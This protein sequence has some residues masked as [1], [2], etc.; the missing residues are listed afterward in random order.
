MPRA[1]IFGKK[2]HHHKDDGA[3]QDDIVELQKELSELREEFDD[4]QSRLQI[5]LTTSQSLEEQ[6]TIERESAKRLGEAL[7]ASEARCEQL[8]HE[9][10]AAEEIRKTAVSQLA[11]E[12]VTHAEKAKEAKAQL[13]LTEQSM[14][15]LRCEMES[16]QK[17]HPGLHEPAQA[18]MVAEASALHV[19]LQ[20]AQES[21]R[22]LVASEAQQAE[23]VKDLRSA[24]A[25][26]E[27]SLSRA[28]AEASSA[29][30]ERAELQVDLETH[31]A[32]AKALQ[33]SF[34]E[35]GMAAQ[36]DELQ[37]LRELDSEVK[38]RDRLLSELRAQL[39]RPRQLAPSMVSP[40]VLLNFDGRPQDKQDDALAQAKLRFEQNSQRSVALLAELN[41]AEETCAALRTEHETLRAAPPPRSVSNLPAP[42]DA[43]TEAEVA[44]LRL[45]IER[46][47]QHRSAQ[48]AKTEEL[49]AELLQ[50]KAG[51]AALVAEALAQQSLAS[52]SALQGAE[53]SKEELHNEIRAMRNQVYAERS[54]L[55]AAFR[56]ELA[57]EEAMC[58]RAQDELVSA[59][60]A[61]EANVAKGA[62]DD[63]DLQHRLQTELAEE[64]ERSARLAEH[65]W[66][67]E[68][69]RNR[70]L[71]EVAQAVEFEADLTTLAKQVGRAAKSIA[72]L[73]K[74][75]V[76]KAPDLRCAAQAASPLEVVA[77]SSLLM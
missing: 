5:A 28:R 58:K 16:L 64:V 60:L 36:L 30:A 12:A 54:D 11:S 29:I 69:G 73:T 55:Q 66:R 21:A 33:A 25:E 47:E 68:E 42:Q 24:L 18:Q 49:Q 38:A 9:R 51:R 63:R 61:L 13:A 17:C 7:H 35:N 8:E 65:A 10:V 52:A 41:E 50:E 39:D 22:H 1:G 46:A 53:A 14:A 70:L 4:T 23:K 62:A 76:P 57:Q 37:R 34:Q 40:R 31:H 27:A 2:H 26:T 59:Q 72:V 44:R 75:T 15:S 20:S 3:A 6:F 67:A 71:C 77:D 56:E 19:E 45:E 43:A 74:G 48:A 32:A